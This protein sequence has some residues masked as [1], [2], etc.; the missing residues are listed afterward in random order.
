MKKFAICTLL[1][2]LLISLSSYT[3]SVGAHEAAIIGPVYEGN[4]RVREHGRDARG[5]DFSIE[6]YD[7]P[8]RYL[9]DSSGNV[10]KV[11]WRHPINSSFKV[12]DSKVYLYLYTPDICF[13]ISGNYSYAKGTY[14]EWNEYPADAKSVWNRGCET[15]FSL[16]LCKETRDAVLS[17]LDALAANVKTEADAEA[18]LPL[19]VQ[20][21]S[22][23]IDYP[24]AEESTPAW[25]I[26]ISVG[27]W[28]AVAAVPTVALINR[29]RKRRKEA[30]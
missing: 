13:V 29:K 8:K 26:G 11:E 12:S 18:L 7:H 21:F 5:F 9:Y 23:P 1:M 6:I 22:A 28:A 16:I 3:M 25:V 20:L 2:F 10:E 15:M 19:L 24:P 14:P 27:A 30:V 4:W 17:G